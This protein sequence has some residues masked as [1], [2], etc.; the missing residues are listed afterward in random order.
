VTIPFGT[1]FAERPFANGAGEGGVLFVGNF[2]HPPNVDAATRLVRRI[3]PRV[4]ERHPDLSLHIVGENPP[5][6]L[7]VA[8]DDG[9]V[10]TGRVPDLV[11]YVEQAAVV[12]AP[13]RFGGGMRVKV[14]EALAAGKPLVASR[15]AVE[16]LDV[17]DGDQLLTAETDE[18]FADR[19]S[20]VLRD[21][22]LRLRLGARARA[23]ANENLTWDRSID[24]YERLYE[25]LLGRP[26]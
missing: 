16:G 2:V 20:L 8:S 1:D 26:V 23:W 6:D 18:E 3:F 19:I 5:P 9:I 22:E 25:R 7:V 17:A 12:A 11:P 14:L 13:L 15:L 4:R 10:V 24:E 21:G